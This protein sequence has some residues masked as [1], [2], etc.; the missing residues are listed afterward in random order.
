MSCYDKV[1]DDTNSFQRTR[2]PSFLKGTLI[3]WLICLLAV[4]FY[5]YDFFL[6]VT[7]SVMIHPLMQQY[8]AGATEIGFISAFYYYA[9]TPLQIPSGVVID[10]YS[11]RWTL[12]LSALLCAVGTLIFAS[13]VNLTAA[14]IGRALMGIGSAFAF[15]G[16]LKL[17]ALWLPK[18]YFALFSGLATAFG[19][20]GAVS[21]DTI[22]SRLVVS[23]GWR[24]SV[25]ITAIAGFIIAA[26]IFLVVRDK[27]SWVTR[28]PKSY[29]SWKHTWKRVFELLKMWRFWING[30][31]GACLFVPVS[32]FASLWGVAFLI[33]S[34]HLSA[35][36]SA[37]AA[38]L[39]FIGAAVGS[40]IAGWFSDLIQNRRLLLFIGTLATTGLSLVLIYISGL[41]P[42]T[43]LILLFLIGVFAGPQILVFAI[44]REISPPRSTGISTASTNFIVTL[45]AAI[46]QPLIG[47][48]LA[49]HWTGTLTASGTPNYT[50]ADYRFSLFVIP[51]ALFIAFFLTFAIPRTRCR[52]IYKDPIKYHG[53]EVDEEST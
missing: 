48:L 5:F 31:V 27:P 32:V 12:T 53:D 1:M 9:Y 13:F 42:I 6:R 51:A 34:Y 17:A 4:L 10:K 38:S 20:I 21:A 26:L 46:F 11:I 36:E 19:V 43:V 45:S 22:L 35:T 47:Y 29:H 52:N 18:R 25:Y 16:A 3:P 24:S 41:S 30:I 49:L 23:I 50:N 15:I 37:T 44:A 39:V 28:M 33:G 14:F 8:G 7:P 2:D 40:P